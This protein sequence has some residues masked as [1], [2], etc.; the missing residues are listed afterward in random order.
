MFK[1]KQGKATEE[2]PFAARKV[3]KLKGDATTFRLYPGRHSV[4]VQVNG[5]DRAQAEFDLT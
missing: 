4:T 2:K 3:H 5:V 1:L